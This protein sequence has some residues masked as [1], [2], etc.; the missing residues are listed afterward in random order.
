MEM[1]RIESLG[2]ELSRLGFGAMRMPTAEEKIDYNASE[3]MI[4]KL[5]EVGVNYYDTAWFYHDGESQKFLRSAL[6]KRY[7][8]DKF[9]IATKMPGHEIKAPEDCA[10]VFES[11]IKDL[12]VECIDFY[13]LHGISREGYEH[14]VSMGAVEYLEKQRAAGRIRFLGFSYHGKNEDLGYVLDQHKWDFCQLQINYYDYS[15]GADFI[16]NAA[17]ERNVPVI[18]MEPVRGGGLARLAPEVEKVFHDA[19]PA[20]STASWALR[21]VAGLPGVAVIL[22]GMSSMEQVLDNIKTFEKYNPLNAGEQEIVANVIDA[23]SKLPVIA[24]TH[25][26]YCSEC[27]SGIKI[28][29]IFSAYNEHLRFKNRWWIDQY[30]TGEKAVHATACVECGACESACPQKISIIQ[31]LKKVHSKMME[32]AGK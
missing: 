21:W 13:L 22:S 6:V 27:P 2:V 16:Y 19:N 20:A 30:V 7:P 1:K 8:R 23:L 32:I 29:R 24:C 5:M 11:Q 4:D 18:V 17:A 31:E 9:Y 12:G 28:P 15:K 3:A 25:C 14:F 10:R 26:N